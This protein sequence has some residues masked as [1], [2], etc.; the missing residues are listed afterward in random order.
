MVA[1]RSGVT[2]RRL[3]RRSNPPVEWSARSGL[4]WSGPVKTINLITRDNGVGLS[5]D[6]ALLESV[7]A[8]AG[9]DVQ[10]V[11]YRSRTMRACDAAI[12]LE[13]FNPQLVKFAHRIV[14]VFNLE[15][16]SSG[17]EPYL[18]RFDQLWAKSREAVEVYQRLRVKSQYT[19]FLSR[20]LLDESVSRTGGCFHLRGHSGLKN[21]EAVI[22]AWRRNPDLPELT[23]VSAVPLKAPAHVRVVGRVE[24][25]ELVRLMNANPIHLCASR[26]EGW[27]HYITEGM[28]T[29]AAVV[30]TDASPMNEH[31]QPDRGVLVASTGT[32]QRWKVV[33]HDVDPDDIAR[34]VKYVIELPQEQRER[35]GYNARSFVLDRNREFAQI[36]LGLIERL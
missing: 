14:G 8:P 5:T 28:S 23:I 36:V 1:T 10:R 20:D 32:R 21:T 15:W 30:T 35:L 26:S 2:R 17:W 13:L 29:R 22:E 11:D 6:M 24:H 18:S 16:F 34:S 31:I 3:I 4:G 9:Y 12:F 33:E 27:G 25:P 7:L 19:G